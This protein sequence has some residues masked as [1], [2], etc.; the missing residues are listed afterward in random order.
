MG[1]FSTKVASPSNSI[2]KL[3]V[4]CLCNS[5]L[6]SV[7]VI[8]ISQQHY[9]R[10]LRFSLNRLGPSIQ[11]LTNIARGIDLDVLFFTLLSMMQDDNEIEVSAE[12]E[13]ARTVKKLM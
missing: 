7:L 8:S 5:P 12:K 6:K 9:Q 2:N 1:A 4:Y 13:I 3:I 11:E 10:L